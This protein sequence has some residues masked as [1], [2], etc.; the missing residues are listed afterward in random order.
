MADPAT[1]PGR[2]SASA[3]LSQRALEAWGDE[4]GAAARAG[5]LPLP[6]VIALRGPL[7]AGKSVLARAVAR[8]A[9]VA[10]PM[11]SPTYNL[12]FTYELDGLVVH[13]LDLYRLDD[14]DDVWELG[15]EELG[16][17]SEIVLIEWP[18]RAE[19]LL[20]VDRWEIRLD[21]HGDDG[22]DG[23][24]ADP[25]AADPIHAAPVARR[26]LRVE[27]RGAAPEPLPLPEVAS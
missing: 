24:T 9:G 20:P 5:E 1:S 6:L 21:F 27:R 17:G 26:W 19:S 7:G 8:G 22:D 13:H 15:W 2:T 11:P 14:P 18:E 4:V 10:G 23:D 25:I 12:L 16:Q 3:S